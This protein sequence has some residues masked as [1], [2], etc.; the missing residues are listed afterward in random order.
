MQTSAHQVCLRQAPA[1]RVRN[2]GAR[3]ELVGNVLTRCAAREVQGSWAAPPGSRHRLYSLVLAIKSSLPSTLAC[4]YFHSSQVIPC[5]GI[6]PAAVCLIFPPTA[7]VTLR[8]NFT[9]NLK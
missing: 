6:V 3:W 8:P 1:A 9:G 5:L 7:S 4:A 2:E